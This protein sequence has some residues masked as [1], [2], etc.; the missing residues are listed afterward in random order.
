[1]GRSPQL[2]FKMLHNNSPCLGTLDIPGPVYG[3]GS[4]N[5]GELYSIQLPYPQNA[6]FVAVDFFGVVWREIPIQ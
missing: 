6:D 3:H 2:Y 4:G 5:T 1:M